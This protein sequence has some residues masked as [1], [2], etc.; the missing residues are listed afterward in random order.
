MTVRTSD[1]EVSTE[2]ADAL[3]EEKTAEATSSRKFTILT[4]YAL[5]ICA[6]SFYA[7]QS[8]SS[9]VKTADKFLRAENSLVTDDLDPRG[10]GKATDDDIYT[11]GSPMLD[12]DLDINN[13]PK[14][15]YDDEYQVDTI[16][17]HL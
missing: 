10:D 5:C 6:W 9:L 17:R 7:Y 12:D 14:N 2:E 3:I 8:Q 11:M 16:G 15:L 1:S 13:A 4:F